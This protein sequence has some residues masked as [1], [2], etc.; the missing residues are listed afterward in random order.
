M[1]NYDFVTVN[2][3]SNHIPRYWITNNG[4]IIFES[5]SGAEAI[6]Y[7]ADNYSQIFIR[8]TIEVNNSISLIDRTIITKPKWYRICC[9]C[10]GII[11]KG[12]GQMLSKCKND[13][14]VFWAHK[15]YGLC[16]KFK[17]GE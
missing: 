17:Y 15:K 16:Q 4:E 8:G 13:G 11:T 7:A 2:S 5:D 12:Q 1:N 6:Q 3:D 14:T 10:N 9:R